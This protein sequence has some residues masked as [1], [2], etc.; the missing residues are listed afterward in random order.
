LIDD[1]FHAGRSGGDV[2]RGEASGVIGHLAGKSD[3]AVLRGD[4]HRGGL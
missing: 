1:S 3:Y 4:I 2:L